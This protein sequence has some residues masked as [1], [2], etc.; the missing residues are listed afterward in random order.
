MEVEVFNVLETKEVTV[1]YAARPSD[2]SP[3]ADRGFGHFPIGMAD[4]LWHHTY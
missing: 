3:L 2:D 1:Q 4:Y